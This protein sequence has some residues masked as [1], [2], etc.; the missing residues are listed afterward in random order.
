MQFKKSLREEMARLGIAD[1][2]AERELNVGFSGGEKKKSEI[3]QLLT[4]KPKLAILDEA[5]SG[6]DVDAVKTVSEG[7]AS[8]R[9]AE[10]AL[11]IITHNA[12][13]VEGID[14]DRV[15]VLDNKKIGFT[16]GAELMGRIAEGGFAAVAGEQ[17]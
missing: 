15:H 11:L 4:L 17:I 2:Y 8:F 16:G 3:L 1:A 14:V 13:L 12:K 10:N 9:N 5:D 6:L 7:I